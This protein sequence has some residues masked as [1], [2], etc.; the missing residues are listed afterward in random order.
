[1]ITNYNGYETRRIDMVM[2]I[3]Y[4][5]DMDKAMEI[6]NRIL[7]GE[8]ACHEGSFTHGGGG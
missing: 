7:D 2:G 5:S 1:M 6:M 4:D 3:G 8:R